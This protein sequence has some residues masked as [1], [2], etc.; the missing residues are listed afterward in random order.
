MIAMPVGYEDVANFGGICTI[1]PKLSHDGWGRVNQDTIVNRKTCMEPTI[2]GESI[3]SSDEGDAGHD[4][5]SR[6]IRLTASID[7]R[8]PFPSDFD[9]GPPTQPQL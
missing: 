3:P 4:L 1:P 5:P 8:H 6:S 9:K 7:S 2:G